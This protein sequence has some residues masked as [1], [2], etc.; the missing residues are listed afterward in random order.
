M[1]LP[2]LPRAPSRAALIAVLASLP[3]A[4]A[5]CAGQ[6]ASTVPIPA[7]LDAPSVTSVLLV[8]DAGA[9]A[10]DDPILAQ[11]AGDAEASGRRGPSVVVFLGDNVYP[12]GVRAEEPE[13]SRDTTAL[14]LQADVISGSSA[15]AVFLP[16]NHDW[17]EGSADGLA[18]VDREAAWVRHA[19]EGGAELTWAPS[20][21]CPGP[22]VLDVGR[23]RLVI[24]DTQWFLH[25]HQRRC[26]DRSEDQILADVTAAIDQAGDRE[27]MLVAHHPL[28]THGPHGG[29]FP[30]DRHLFP[31][32]D[33]WSEAFVPL[34]VLGTAYVV[35]R[36]WGISDQD[37]EGDANE[38]MRAG[39]LAAIR[40][41]D[42][43]P[44]FYAAGHEHSLQV[45]RGA[46]GEPAYHLVSG[47]ASKTTPVTSG[48]GTLFATSARGYMKVE[49]GPALIQISAVV[50]GPSTPG[51][52][53]GWCLRIDRL[54]RVETSC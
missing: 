30:P 32:R 45:L 47:S 17:D 19:A 29:Y 33:F 24:L 21:G 31:L 7:G 52:P 46:D 1:T 8:G 39:L 41:A 9:L 23:V 53:E 10:P 13:F 15:R 50:D 54:S 18:A 40:S 20:A 2:T 4:A 22:D 42:R 26:E 34:P 25:D 3:V 48:E 16:G 38:R 14:A 36:V 35:S 49:V 43:R 12:S 5:S 51:A 28:R 37:L 6:I 11:L 27:V 44:A